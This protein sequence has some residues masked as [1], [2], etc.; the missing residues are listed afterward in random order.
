MKRLKLFLCAALLFAPL[1]LSQQGYIPF[2]TEFDGSAD[3]YLRGGGLTGAVDGKLGIASLW[4]RI[5]EDGRAQTIY[6]ATAGDCF[7]LIKNSDNTLQLLLK[8]ATPT[9]IWVWDIA[10]IPASSDWLHVLASWDLGNAFD[11]VYINDVASGSAS[12]FTDDTIDYTCAD[13]SLGA[14]T[15]GVQNFNGA[16]SELYINTAESLD[17]TI[18]A[19]RRFF[20]TADLKPV[21]LGPG[22]Y[23]PT[24]VVSIVCMQTQFNGF[25]Q[26]SGSGGD[27]TPQDPVTSTTGP[28][29]IAQSVGTATSAYPHTNATDFDG[30]ADYYTSPD[31]SGAV[32]G[33]LG[34]VNFWFRLDGTDG[35]SLRFL[36]GTGQSLDVFR[37]NTNVI[38]V[39][40]EN[41]SG[42][43]ILDLTSSS[44]YLASTTW[45]HLAASWNLGNGTGFLYIDG[46]DDEAGSP[47]LTDDDIDYTL[48]D[49][50]IGAT[51]TGSSNLDGALSEF[52]FNAAE[53]LDLSVAADLAKLISADLEPVDLGPA[54]STPT[55][56]AAIICMTNQFNG[57]GS[58]EG[59]GG[60]FVPQ[61]PTSWTAGPVPVELLPGRVGTA[62]GR[63]R[64]GRLRGRRGLSR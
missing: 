22:C 37:T 29:A 39:R 55:G 64:G 62:Q 56:T 11:E 21:D 44:T 61:D 47:T 49:Y 18:E 28:V 34:T 6:A 41:A 38:V 57:F 50:A 1:L 45:H 9:F 40:G 48:A 15:S 42:T 10:A 52:Y 25:G 33:Q 23:K 16:L 14:T 59:T 12:T 31:L 53:F 27:F 36:H 32:D 17:I 7:R 30:T 5:N 19:N 8:N 24:G 2:A 35:A 43:R 63:G 54:C 60:D 58:N 20:I 26:N 4:I 3:H 46:V 51:V 13:F